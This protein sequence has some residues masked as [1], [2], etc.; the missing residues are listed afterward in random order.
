MH[1]LPEKYI[2][3]LCVVCPGLR[4]GKQSAQSFGNVKLFLLHIQYI[5]VNQTS[6]E[7]TIRKTLLTIEKR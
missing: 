2:L 7:E 1:T 4:L 5:I 6:R 3:G